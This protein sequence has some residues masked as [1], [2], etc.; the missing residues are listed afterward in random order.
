MRTRSNTLLCPLVACLLAARLAAQEPEEPKGDNARLRPS[1]LG[2]DDAA[3]ARALFDRGFS[4]LAQEACDTILSL[5]TSGELDF[6]EILEAKSLELDLQMETADRLPAPLE[7]LGAVRDLIQKKEKLIGDNSRTEVAGRMREA[8]PEDYLRLGQALVDALDQTKDP[9]EGATLRA[10]GDATFTEAE[11]QMRQRITRFADQLDEGGPN[12]SYAERQHLLAT[13]NLGRTLYFHGLLHPE[14]SPEQAER[15]EEC[16]DVF[17][18]LALDYPDVLS[19]YQGYIYQGL[20][21]SALGEVEAATEDFDAA[22]ALRETWPQDE[23]SGVWQIQSSDAGDVI[24]AAVYQKILALTKADRHDEVEEVAQDFYTTIPD[25]YLTSQGL[26]VVAAHADSRLKAGDQGRAGELAQLLI[27]EDPQG[28]GASLGR[29]LLA[30]MAVSGASPQDPQGLVSVAETLRAQGS[31]DLARAHCRKAIE[32]ARG[33]AGAVEAGAQACTLLGSTYLAQNR[34]YEASI[35]FDLAEDFFPGASTTPEALWRSIDCYRKLFFNEKRPFFDKRQQ[36]RITLLSTKYAAHPRS[37]Q[38]ILLRGSTLEDEGKFEEAAKLYHGIQPSSPVFQEAQA[39]AARSLYLQARAT[40]D[41]AAAKKLQTDAERELRKSLDD[42]AQAIQN[43]LD[44]QVQTQLQ[45]TRF[46]VIETLGRLLLEVGRPAEVPPL[47][48]GLE[49]DTT[50]GR[51]EVVWTMRIQAL[52]AQ[53]KVAE[54]EALFES[55]LRTNPNSPAIAAT[56]GVLAR[57][58]DQRATD[59]AGTDEAGAREL[60]VKAVHYYDVSIRPQLEGQIVDEE[61]RTV[62]DRLYSIGF[63]LNDVP[64]TAQTFVDWSDEPKAP[65]VWERAAAIYEAL[66][67][68]AP[69][70]RT[71]IQLG[72]CLGLLGRWEEAAAVYARLFDAES[73]LEPGGRGFNQQVIQAKPELLNAYLEWGVAEHRLALVDGSE[74]RKKR[75]EAIFPRVIGAATGQSRLWWAAKYHQAQAMYDR[76][77]YIPSD[78]VVRDLNRGTDENFD[79]GEFGYQPRFAALE[80]DLAKKPK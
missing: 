59:L 32:R 66:L 65:A 33:N 60:W 13:W 50:E 15:F 58:L 41:E 39:R 43:T 70:Y 24:S 8:L 17:S 72:R 71:E 7:R 45:R 55:L 28:I 73:I 74:D 3:F 76:G 9:A 69:S 23:A 54:A 52:Q 4:D 44:V 21:H 14:G 37:Q 47:L 19:T 2:R 30:K 20:C 26:A 22:I 27:E 29:G 5:E 12:T 16:V 56:A 48:E 67:A 80:A 34:L 38:I 78:S 10:E 46:G 18:D 77:E 63:E 79:K 53:G 40:K 61:I 68:R 57:G 35:A 31:I 1:I 11:D 36:E 75:A 51:A 64:E 62:A 25:A 42:L 6:E 49:A